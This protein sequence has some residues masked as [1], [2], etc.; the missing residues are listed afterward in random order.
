MKLRS[1]L[2]LITLSFLLL[3]WAG[4]QW[5]RQMETLLREGQEQALLASAEAL[6]RAVAARP[7]DLPEQGPS[8]FVQTHARAP[9]LDGRFGD[10]SGLASR[11]FRGGDGVERLG[12]ALGRVDDALFLRVEVTASHGQ[13][14][15]AAWPRAAL[16]DH[17]QLAMD[18]TF[19][20]LQLRLANAADGAL[21][22]ISD[23]GTAAPITLHGVWRD[24]PTGYAVELQLPQGLLPERLGL[25][26]QLTAHG[27]QSV[28]IGTAS[29]SPLLLWP[30]LRR[31]DR[32]ARPLLPLLPS[33]MRARLVAAEG[34]VLA[35][36]GDL[37]ESTSNSDLPWWR[38]ELYQQLLY[39]NDPW[40]LDDLDAPRS[41]RAEVWQALS[42]VPATAWRRDREASRLILAAAVPIVGAAG[43]RG[44]LL[45]E[46][47]HQTL[48]LM[49]RGLG[50]LIGSTLLVLL[51]AGGV[52]LLF[53]SRLSWRIGRL[54]N[55]AENALERDGS[56]RSFPR[57]TDGDEIGDLSRSF[58]RL[59]DEVAANQ[60]YLRSLAGKLSHE[61]NTP[62]AIVRGALDNIAPQ[63]LSSD[64]SA[65]VQRARSGS[66]RLA[67]IVRA[68]SEASRIEQAIASAETEDFDLSRLLRDCASNHA[69]LLAP[70]RFELRLPDGPVAICG[71]PELIAQA[72]DKLID[73]AR[74]FTPTDGWVRL[75]LH[76]HGDVARIAVANQ[77]PLLPVTMR[78]R[79]FESMVSLRPAQR[80]DGVHLGF[81][82]YLVRLVADL[83][84]GSA[85]AED[86][87]DGSG[88]EFALHLRRLPRR[89]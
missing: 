78:G 57:S 39:A 35:E 28:S 20:A 88:V 8:L 2:L 51:G 18:G 53:A 74:S 24:T 50:G 45:L 31:S 84:R 3:P 71:A 55:A 59:L 73:N 9:T 75:S 63:S 44:A 15:D 22:V 37:P 46:R 41:D 27:D 23:D 49:D 48:L 32:L 62:L 80:S 89:R 86:L 70:R 64:A 67:A 58:A 47:E 85:T 56:L 52:L 43:V 4:W 19:G 12:L 66:D 61:L 79:L 69:D 17:L 14:A 10:W 7:G 81:G 34:W 21:R 76:L 40:T 33:D 72:L 77:G 30:L 82:L 13:R 87:L 29:E 36:A 83:H 25:Q 1:K 38:R 5:L 6:A 60:D 54:R 68:M 11:G 16:S 65:C 42:G 26:V